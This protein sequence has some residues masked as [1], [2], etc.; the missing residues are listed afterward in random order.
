MSTATSGTQSKVISS[1]KCHTSIS[2]SISSY[3]AVVP[4]SSSM[5]HTQLISLNTVITSPY[6][7]KCIPKQNF[8]HPELKLPPSPTIYTR[9]HESSYIWT[10][11][12]HDEIVFSKR[13]TRGFDN[14][15]VLITQDQGT[16]KQASKTNKQTKN[17]Q[18]NKPTKHTKLNLRYQD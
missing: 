9:L 8:K 14:N 2:Q 10:D 13:H 11:T 3:R 6:L 15:R 17:K 7:V 5:I 18:R 4:W 12:T 1:R 16:N